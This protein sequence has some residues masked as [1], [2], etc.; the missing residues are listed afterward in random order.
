MS[1]R[2]FQWAR[3]KNPDEAAVFIACTQMREGIV[4]GD[5]EGFLL[6]MNSVAAVNWENV[7][8]EVWRCYRDDKRHG[9]GK[10]KL[11]DV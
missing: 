1:F 2:T 7:R 11:E 9:V 10:F 3:P 8:R 4:S 5:R 6:A